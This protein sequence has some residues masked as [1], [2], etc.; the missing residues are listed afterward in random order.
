MSVH[1][2]FAVADTLSP[3]A[4]DQIPEQPTK[5]E[6]EAAKAA[7][8]PRSSDSRQHFDESR[9]QLQMPDEEVKETPKSLSDDERSHRH[10]QTAMS[11]ER[12]P[13]DRK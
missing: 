6:K 9:G 1:T 10:G 8:E 12:I 4:A 11:R 13:T 2:G 3:Q 5:A 7:L